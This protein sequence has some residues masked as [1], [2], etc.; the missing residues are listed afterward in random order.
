ML[1]QSRLCFT[2]E[3]A[4]RMLGNHSEFRIEKIRRESNK[5]ADALAW[6]PENA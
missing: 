6:K 2:V 1:N 4:R 3:E 5:A